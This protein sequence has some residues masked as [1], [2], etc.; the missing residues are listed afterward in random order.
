MKSTN[1]LACVLL[2]LLLASSA[3]FGQGVGT[4]GGISGTVVDPTGAALAKA[5]VV[6]IETSKGIQHSTTTDGA[7]QYRFSGLAPATYS[8][9]AQGPGFASEVQKAV[10]VTLGE[11]ATV[12]FQLKLSGVSDQVDVVEVPSHSSVVDTERSSQSNTLGQMYINDLPIDRRDYLTFTLLMPGVSESNV[13]AEGHDSRLIQ[14]PQS[15]LSFYGSNGRGNDITVD[16]GAFNGYSGF[17]MANVSQDAVQEFQINRS[18]Y[19]ASLGGATGASINIVTKSGSNKVHGTLYG[20]FRNDAL[21][22][23]DPFAFSEALAPGQPFSL[24]AQGQPV[25]NALSRQ[26]FG[27]TIGLPIRK[28]KTFF[29][30]AYE[31]LHH[32]QQATVPILL[33]S[34]IFAPTADQSSIFAGLAANGAM[35]VPCLPR[36]PVMSASVCAGI[37][38]NLLTLNPGASPLK[39][40]VVDQF[41]NNGGLLPFPIRSHEFSGRVD[42]IFNDTN[43][44]SLRYI[45]AHLSKSDPSA[46]SNSGF[47]SGYSELTWTNS[48]QGSWLHTFDANTLNEFR[49]Q[50]NINQYNFTPNE[51]GGPDLG[52]SGFG[53]FGRNLTLPNISTER[54]YEFADNFT[55]L[56]GHH[57]FQMGANEL[58][59]GNRTAS[60]IFLSGFFTFGS[61]PGGI[62]SPCLQ[63]PAACGLPGTA[64]ASINSIQSAGLGLPQAYIQGFGDPTV[65][66][67]MPWTTLYWQD[68][69]TARPNFTLSYGL[70]YEVDHRSFIN[71]DYN[72]VAPRVSF[73]W[74]PFKDHKTVVRGGYGIYYAPIMLQVDTNTAALGNQNNSR[75]ISVAIV[76]L[77]GLPGNPGLNSAAIFQTLF[78]QGKIL[79]GQPA[80]GTAACITPADLAQ[81]GLGVST[82]GPLPALSYTQTAASNFRSP[83]SQQA[84]LGIEREIGSGFSVSA[85]YVYVHTLKLTRNGDQNL[86]PGAPI[87]SGVAGTN[88]LP[89]QNWG[90][91]QCQVA[92]N[93]PCF[94]NPQLFTSNLFTSTAAALYQGGILEVK[95]SFSHHFSVLAN[96]T[97][98]KAMDDS[99]DFSYWGSNQLSTAGERSVSAFD[100]RHKVVVA[101]VI[102]SPFAGRVLSGFQLSPVLSYNSSRPFNLYSGTDTNGDRTSFGDRPPGA[103]RNTGIGPNYV[104]MD[105]R[106]SWRFKIKE[107]SSL[108]LMIEGFNIANRTNYSRVNDV[109]GSTFA[110]PFNVH[111]N[112]SLQPNQPLAYISDFP[113][114]EIQLGARFAF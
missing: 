11:T 57:M 83:Y 82:T 18:N 47:S 75:L 87:S 86:L 44:G 53:N 4:S 55:K 16:G 89:F 63:V 80:A 45:F 32:D 3:A 85:S 39:K 98:S 114:R 15:G 22:A 69:W 10:V 20:F 28:D 27:G 95:K 1:R 49:T 37:L 9:T 52:I 48:L 62:I 113:K 92:V 100:Q 41:V 102:E 79:C 93:N 54:D 21:D 26:Q 8:V 19:S 109:V 29:F 70:R 65:K 71:T 106:L 110:P 96:Y 105:M 76:P 42:H 12:D 36:R 31:G 43:Q 104:S 35:Q 33:N 61:L 58:L 112:A 94:V 68:Q 66:T 88:G 81:F 7:G 111:A 108:Q 34:N 73:A 14:V 99:L 23:R 2:C 103:G 67:M 46:R 40:L 90:A 60:S 6:A 56:H 51:L 64:P 38:Q 25:K 74:D 50:W 5:T 78:A 30:A 101:S 59:R 107:K 13:I 97:Y 91:P 17:V 84:S 72:N 77:N 24:N